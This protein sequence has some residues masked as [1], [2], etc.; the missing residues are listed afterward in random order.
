METAR[1]REGEL[2]ELRDRLA[3][4]EQGRRREQGAA[5]VL[6]AEVESLKKQLDEL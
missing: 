6:R 2:A 3:A 5:D 4:S 1:R